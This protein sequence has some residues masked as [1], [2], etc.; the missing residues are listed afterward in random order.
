M[1]N[2]YCK[3]ELQC[4]FAFLA[5][6]TLV[7]T[8]LWACR[9]VTIHALRRRPW[10][11]SQLQRLSCDL[12]PQLSTCRA[13]QTPLPSG[14]TARQRYLEAGHS[15]YQVSSVL[16]ACRALLCPTR[17]THVWAQHNRSE[18][19][20]AKLRVQR[21]VERRCIAPQPVHGGLVIS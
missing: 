1:T 8:L 6:H 10:K 20:N 16:L 4:S 19:H 5:A 2:N 3:Q 18:W 12:F 13:C 17:A 7:E 14:C 21:F 9:M 11:A 15:T